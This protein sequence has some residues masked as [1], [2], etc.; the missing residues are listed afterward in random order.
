MVEQ[1]EAQNLI[2]QKKKKEEE[3]K[4]YFERSVCADFPYG[5]LISQG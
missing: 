4:P 3:K 2:L 1:S 5:Y